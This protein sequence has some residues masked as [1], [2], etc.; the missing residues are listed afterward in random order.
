MSH[1][2]PPAPAG[3]LPPEQREQPAGHRPG[4][5]PDAR[6]PGLVLAFLCI[7]QFMVF[8]DGMCRS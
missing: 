6:R 2:D 7:A 1:A 3:A 4:I 5:A 8:L